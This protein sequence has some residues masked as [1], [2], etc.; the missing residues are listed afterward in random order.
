MGRDGV[1]AELVHGPRHKKC[2]VTFSVP[3]I[4]HFLWRGPYVTRT[5]KACLQFGERIH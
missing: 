4:G 5:D 2:Q 1:R 3:P